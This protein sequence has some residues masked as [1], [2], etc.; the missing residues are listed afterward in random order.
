MTHPATAHPSPAL[1][2]RSDAPFVASLV[3][4]G[5]TYVAL[6]VAMVV[7][8]AFHTSWDDIDRVRGAANLRYA[9]KLSLVSC[10]VTTGL[11]L[12][13]GIPLAYAMSRWDDAPVRRA[14]DRLVPPPERM[15]R[16]LAWVSRGV[17]LL[18]PKLLVDAVID[19]PIVLPPLVVGLCLLILFQT[20]AG[21]WAEGRLEAVTRHPLALPLL[22]WALVPAVVGVVTVPLVRAK[23]VGTRAARWGAA[24]AAGVA[25]G[26]AA[27]VLL[28]RTGWGLT[29]ERN[30]REHLL[31][32]RVTYAIPS[33][34]VA[35]FTVSCAFAVRTLRVT[36]DQIP[37]RNEQVALTLGCT[38]GQAFRLVTLPEA[39]A[40]VL[41]AAT[42]AWA[43]ALGEFGP[44]LVF[45]GATRFRT[46]V[47]STSV[48][49]HLSIGDLG[50]A[51]AVSLLMVAAA[52]AVM[53]LMRMLGAEGTFAK[54]ESRRA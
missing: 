50:G 45:S 37:V 48:F 1:R 43:R 39:R 52:V 53:V 15:P 12:L 41:T 2:V 51:V 7:A 18:N 30:L 9:I 27:F 36:F 33:I 17:H 22:A 19:I 46:E 25:A 6:I 4:L 35:Q 24:V 32:A 3:I 21:R 54:V 23:A 47:L 29:F 13:V 44:I 49:L 42:L 16:G 5:G 34:I 40:G 26:F 28:E 8:E 14:L 20:P 31:P 11:C 38:R 10:F